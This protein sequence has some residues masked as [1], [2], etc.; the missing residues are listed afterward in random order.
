M[1]DA[2]G[3][4]ALILVEVGSRKKIEGNPAL[5]PVGRMISYFGTYAVNEADKVLSYKIVGASFPDWDG[6]EQKRAI[7]TLDAAKLVTKSV[8]PI[9]SAQGPFVPVV[10]FTRVK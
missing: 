1:F 2:G 5:N 8:A 3:R 4:F 6:T 9:P 10:T 7:A